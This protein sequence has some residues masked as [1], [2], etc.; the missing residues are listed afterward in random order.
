MA[1]SDDENDASP[2]RKR[3]RDESEQSVDSDD[4]ERASQ[5]TPVGT[6]VGAVVQ[7]LFLGDVMDN[8]HIDVLV[9]VV[10]SIKVPDEDTEP[11]DMETMNTIL[12]CYAENLMRDARENMDL[13][14]WRYVSRFAYEFAS[15]R[16][17][18]EVFDP[19]K[20][21]IRY[22]HLSQD[23]VEL[24]F[25]TY[26][27]EMCRLVQ[28]MEAHKATSPVECASIDLACYSCMELND[29]F[30]QQMNMRYVPSFSECVERFT[31]NPE[32]LEKLKSGLTFKDM[33]KE[34]PL[35]N[36][37]Y[38]IYV[39]LQSYCA[40]ILDE[41]IYYPVFHRGFKTHAYTFRGSIEQVI[42]GFYS[43]IDNPHLMRLVIR[44]TE[45]VSKAMDL[46][47]HQRQDYY[48]PVYEP[49]RTA[50]SFGDGVY[51]GE[52]DVFYHYATQSKMIP[53]S[54]ITSRFI[55]QD[56]GDL[57]GF[58]SSHGVPNIPTDFMDIDVPNVD[59]IMNFQ[60]Y[61]DINNPSED[62]IMA[63]RF[64]WGM[65][66]R[67]FF[68]MSSDSMQV[69]PFLIGAGGTGKSI[70]IEL[71]RSVYERSKTANIGPDSSIYFSLESVYQ[72]YIFC[73]SEVNAKHGL[74]QQLFQQTVTGES[75]SINR[76]N[77]VTIDV[78]WNTRQIWA[79]NALPP[80]QDTS[81]S[82]SRRVVSFPFTRKPMPPNI[83]LQAAT[84]LERA[85]FIIKACKAYLWMREKVNANGSFADLMPQV[86][87]RFH[88]SC[89]DRLNGVN[90]FLNDPEYVVYGPD[91][92]CELTILQQACSQYLH[93]RGME[94]LSQRDFTFETS[95]KNLHGVTI[96]QENTLR[97]NKTVSVQ[98]LH[99]IGLVM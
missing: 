94:R 8:R 81:G 98:M 14:I 6:V 11:I 69:A 42:R 44:N 95:V 17:Q 24:W 66:G 57:F 77:K 65:I 80:W 40:R 86:L 22:T 85:R 99:G 5:Q 37:I 73:V 31:Q 84:M 88:S 83:K 63:V 96:N 47:Q 56:V 30:R 16:E 28:F 4:D 58:E 35:E 76:K 10:L 29:R 75:V 15:W 12:C 52:K 53:S 50:W 90:S 26:Q 55:N 1:S 46:I 9:E 71:I 49:H 3:K 18:E 62:E 48:L 59:F 82:V 87:K 74:N 21:A 60:L 45:I 41:N 68:P 92:K 19:T 36:Y 61:E 93:N 38:E 78:V 91:E 33:K 7:K 54:L 34:L 97:R 13:T 32:T 72:A 51:D 67:L 70:I 25:K 23:E 43:F 39:R 2:N 79:M 20:Q 64:L 27:M 89:V